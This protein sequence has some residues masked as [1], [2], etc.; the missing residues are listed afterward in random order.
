MSADLWIEFPA[1]ESCGRGEDTTTELNVTYNLSGML[2]E[3][4]FNGWDWCR[5]KPAPQ[6]GAHMLAVL[7]GMATDPDRWRAMNPPNGWGDYDRR[8]QGRM[9]LFA[10]KCVAAKAG[11]IGAW[12]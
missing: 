11:V 8:L 3:A 4:G 5:G 6:V 7:D 1:C 12:L 2:R 9:R 10:E